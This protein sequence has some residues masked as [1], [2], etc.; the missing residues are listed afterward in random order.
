MDGK[1]ALKDSLAIRDNIEKEK[2]DFVAPIAE[3][4]KPIK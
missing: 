4:Y 3:I 1:E 2:E